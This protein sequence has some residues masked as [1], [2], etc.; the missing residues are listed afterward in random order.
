[1]YLSFQ[2]LNNF[3]IGFLLVGNCLEVKMWVLG[4]LIATGLANISRSFQQTNLE[5]KLF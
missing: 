3:K 2:D 4:V 5:K 1:M